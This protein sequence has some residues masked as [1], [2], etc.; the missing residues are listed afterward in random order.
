MHYREI[1]EDAVYQRGRACT[2]IPLLESPPCTQV[3]VADGED[4][5]L[6]VELVRLEGGFVDEPGL[7]IDAQCTSHLYP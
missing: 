6:V 2:R 1:V 5:L 7:W 4:G 3:A